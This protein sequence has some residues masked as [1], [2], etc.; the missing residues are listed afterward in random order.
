[1]NIDA[2]FELADL[3]GVVRRRT[4]AVLGIALVV[5]LGAFWLSMSLPNEYE[6]YAT[7]L[8]QPQTVD[9]KLVEAGVAE[10][11]LNRRLHLMAAQILS[12]PRLSRI[13]DELGLYEDE[14]K[15]LPRDEVISMM[16]DHVEVSPVVPE[17]EQQQAARRRDFVI[18]QFRLS[19]RDNDPA[20]ARDVAQRLANDF[21][22]EH[23]ATRVR[24]S[25][26]SLEFIEAELTRLSG[27]IQEVEGKVAEV[28]SENPGR[29]PEDA[30][31]NQR[32]LERIIAE[33]ANA[34]RQAVAARSDEAFFRSQSAT[35]REL[36]DGGGPSGLSNTPQSRA[37]SLELLLGEYDA[38]GFTDKHPDVVRTKAELALLKS[39]LAGEA[40]GDE[41]EPASFAEQ[42][43]AAEAERAQ[44]RWQHAEGEIARLEQQQEEVQ[45]LLNASPEVAEELDA[46][47]REYRHLFASYQDFSNRRLEA[48]VQADLE[49]RQLGEQ[50]RV[51][52]A[53]FLAPEPV[54][55]NR[56]V[57]V[58]I[59]IFFGIALGAGIGIVLEAAD[60]SVHS[61]RQ[62]QSSVGL[63]VLAAIPEIWLE[64]DRLKLRRS[65]IRTAFATFTVVVFGLTGGIVNYWWV[66][67][68]VGV[69]Q[70]P[71]ELER[72]AASAPGGDE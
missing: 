67:G 25:Q 30:P 7:L 51:L 48:G 42:N 18:D 5:S 23:I 55:P 46:L 43:A 14:S 52:E 27:A 34:R 22:E 54:S 56:I 47:E 63:P 13:I 44:L 31:A 33:L 1:M 28:K 58:A 8:V 62:L 20:K 32:R 2:G 72:A 26:K 70:P 4:R 24:T 16:R 11:D 45:R 29:L 38:R 15:Y 9:P 19:F 57:I 66:N 69:E 41:N 21:I 59:G 61:V 65:R 36:T 64:A 50:F 37:R 71:A 6:S 35:A 12:R 60:P 53:A 3:K 68:S 39:Q 10:S 49:R 40:D 17:L